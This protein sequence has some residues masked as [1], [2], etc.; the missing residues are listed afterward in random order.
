MSKLF[1]QE[2]YYHKYNAFTYYSIWPNTTKCR[3]QSLI[4]HTSHFL[5]SVISQ[6]GINLHCYRGGITLDP[7]IWILVVDIPLQFHPFQLLFVIVLPCLD[8]FG[9]DFLPIWE[10]MK[11]PI[12]KLYLSHTANSAPIWRLILPMSKLW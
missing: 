3:F 9:F 7:W 1:A 4:V 2:W 8:L 5:G 10:Q 11:W 12:W 6:N